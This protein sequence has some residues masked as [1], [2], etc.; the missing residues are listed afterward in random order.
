MSKS[1]KSQYNYSDNEQ[2]LDIKKAVPIIWPPFVKVATHDS[3]L[4]DKALEGF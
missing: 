2:S 4:L 3:D 1:R